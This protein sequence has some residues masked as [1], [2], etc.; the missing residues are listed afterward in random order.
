MTNEPS[1]QELL[2][3]LCRRDQ[4]YP[5][6]AYDFVYQALGFVQNEMKN[7]GTIKEGPN[8]VTG[9]QLSEGCRD[10]A[11]QE[12]GM[13]AGTVL[14]S[15]NI[16]ETADIGELVYN[17]ININLMTRTDTDRKED[18]HNVYDMKKAFAIGFS[19]T[20]DGT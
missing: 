14:N 2:Q 3:E 5:F 20:F 16:K 4:R 18:F 17:L 7:K 6:E 11:L 13:M 12:Y 1:P 10:F 19:F 8:H 9:Q 15:W